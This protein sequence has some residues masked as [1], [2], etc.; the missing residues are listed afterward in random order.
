MNESTLTVDMALTIALRNCLLLFVQLPP[1]QKKITSTHGDT[2]WESE[3][4]NLLPGNKRSL[5][6]H[7]SLLFCLLD[8]LFGVNF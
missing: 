3:V 6:R 7:A 8:L 4:S 1:F 2:L 5:V